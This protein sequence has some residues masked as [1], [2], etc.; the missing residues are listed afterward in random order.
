MLGTAFVRDLLL[1]SL[2]ARVIYSFSPTPDG[3]FTRISN[4]RSPS[5]FKS[6]GSS[7]EC[8]GTLPVSQGQG[9]S[10]R[11]FFQHAIRGFSAAV[12]SNTVFQSASFAEEGNNVKLTDVYFGVGCF[13]HI[14]HEFGK[15]EIQFKH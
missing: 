14:Q 13:W 9:S 12:V 2:A 8:N 15:K 4:I 1:F 10:R 5:C 7:D 11:F 3:K 6:C